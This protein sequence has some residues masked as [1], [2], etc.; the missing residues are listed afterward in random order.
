MIKQNADDPRIGGILRWLMTRRTGD[1][2][3]STRDT[4]CVLAA[5]CDYLESKPGAAQLGGTL[6]VQLNGAPLKTWTLS[7]QANYAADLQVAVSGEKLKSG[8]NTI[9]LERS[10][11]SSPVFYA[12][13]LRQTIGGEDI[14]P[15]PGTLK[16]KREYLRVSTPERDH[17]WEI[18]TEPT[19]NRLAQGDQIRVQ[20]TFTAPRDMAY[21]LIEDAYPSGCEVTQRGT[22][23]EDFY[24]NDYRYEYSSIQVSNVDVRD[25]RIAFFARKVSAGTHTISYH[26]R[27]QTPGVYHVL[28]AQMQ[29]MYDPKLRAESAENRVEV[30]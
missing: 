29:A 16:I 24:G 5:L 25:D 14:A 1:Y 18:K 26:L 17:K 20:L 23:D 9:S 7:P 21:V 28:P 22:A 19:N 30:R 2:W 12:V 11:G 15:L 4:S 10:G 13:Q 8:T 27:A 6:K 3:Q